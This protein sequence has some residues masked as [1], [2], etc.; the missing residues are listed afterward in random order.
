MPRFDH[1]GII[2]IILNDRNHNF[3]IIF[4]DIDVQLEHISITV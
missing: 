3:N 2:L 4:C 1:Y